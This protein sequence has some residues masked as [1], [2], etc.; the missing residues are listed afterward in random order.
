MSVIELKL[1]TKEGKTEYYSCDFIPARKYLEYLKMEE[2]LEQKRVT[3]VQAVEKRT[4]FVASIF[5]GI[6]AE[7]LYNGLTSVELTKVLTDIVNEIMGI[8]D[9]DPKQS[10][11]V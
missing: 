11:S 1:R 10:E 3:T 8:G 2:E 5:E 9:D 6:T 4:K 7:D